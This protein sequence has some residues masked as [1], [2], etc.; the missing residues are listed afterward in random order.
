MRNALAAVLLSVTLQLHAGFSATEVLVPAVGRTAGAG[1]SDFHTTLWVTNPGD[2]AVDVQIR[3][4]LAGQPNTTPPVFTDRLAPGANRVYENFAE[5]LFGLRNV[6]GAAQV[7]ASAKVLVTARV[8]HHPGGAPESGTT[9]LAISGVPPAFGVG[10]GEVGTV[11]GVRHS[12]HYRYNVFVLETTGQPV[13]LD[14][15]ITDAAGA[16]LHV[17]PILLQGYEQRVFSVAALLGGANLQDGG[18][19]IT[20]TLGA[21]RVVAVGS[22]VANGSHDGTAFPMSF[23]TASLIGPPGPPGPPGPEGPRGAQGPSGPRGPG[24][25][26][27][28]PGPPG[29]QGPPGLNLPTGCGSVQLVVGRVPNDANSSGPGF[30]SVVSGS[31]TVTVTFTDPSF[32]TP[33]IVTHAE[34]FNGA[35]TDNAAQIGAVTVGPGRTGNSVVLGFQGLGFIN[36]IAARCRP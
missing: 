18:I 16:V 3:F 36:F 32:D 35:P 29:P 22:L 23:S 30:T 20:P 34:V 9:G 24:G 4:L 6:I 33:V 31:G 12:P 17:T 13:A 10:K 5:R 28:P 2:E 14:L 15:A 7:S 25:P 26:Q 11:Q 1:G 19:R 27:G 8:Y 21:G